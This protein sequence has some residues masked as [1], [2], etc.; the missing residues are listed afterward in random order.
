V[1][2]ATLPPGWVRAELTDVVALN[3][4]PDP[5]TVDDACLVSFVPMAAVEAGTGQLDATIA[6]P[7]SEVRKGYM[8]FR[9]G[10]VLF[11][12]ITPC[13][14]NGKVAVATGLLN[15]LAAGSTEFH[16]LRPLGGVEPKF[17]LYFLLQDDFR[18]LARSKM[19]GA[20]GQLR[21][22]REFMETAQIPVPPLREQRRI[23]AEIETQFT[24]LD[25][26][27]AAL[28]RARANLRRYRAATLAQLASGS[29]PM[30]PLGEV[31]CIQGG[32]QKQP[33]RAPAAN[34]FPFLRVANVLRGRLDLG[35]IHRIELFPGE[36]AKLRL[37]EG[38]LLVVEGNGSPSEIGRMAIW[39]G[40]I[41]DCVHQ[42]HIIRVRLGERLLPRFVEAYWNS[43]IGQLH[44]QAV[45]SS[46]S[47]LYTLS[48]RK[49]AA[50]SVPIPSVEEQGRIVEE[51]ERRMSV[52]SEIASAIDGNLKRTERLRQAILRKAFAGQLLP[53]DP[54]D[55]P[56]SVLL[57]R[58]REERAVASGAKRAMVRAHRR[59][60]TPP[61]VQRALL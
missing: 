21:V 47:G 22:P 12:K 17:I 14:E 46:T 48:V 34:A 2:D 13:M 15:G 54:S 31:S 57:E 59:R 35:E 24:R 45:A 8:L 3:P 5:S 30:A 7:W 51:V 56:A 19:R 38:D 49:I 16:V 10:D 27:V 40:S 52:A 9:E 29:W 36:L 33:K 41:S 26:A 44:V 32:I 43:P 18:R 39:D 50:L 4:R 61:V 37:Q 28:E 58:I 60:A 1:K 20:A 55:E 23:V 42:N 6:R 25:A 53:Q 11:A